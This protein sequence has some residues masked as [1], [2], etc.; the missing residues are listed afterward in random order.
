MWRRNIEA[1]PGVLD[2]VREQLAGRQAA[3]V[4]VEQSPGSLDRSGRTAAILAAD[5]RRV[6]VVEGVPIYRP[7]RPS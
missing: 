7:R 1:I 2:S 4:A 3:L 5:Y 6:A